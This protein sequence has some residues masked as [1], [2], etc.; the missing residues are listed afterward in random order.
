MKNFIWIINL[1]KVINKI[2]WSH[3]GKKLA[4]GDREGKINIFA[5]EKDVFTIKP[6]D[7]TKF[8]K[9]INGLLENV[10]VKEAEAAAVEEK[11]K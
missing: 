2:S 8:D 9:V 11:K 4:A 7:F 3:D 6:D 10:A 5:S 1:K